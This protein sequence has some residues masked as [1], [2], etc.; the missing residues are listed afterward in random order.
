MTRLRTKKERKTMT[1]HGNILQLQK[2]SIHFPSRV[3]IV[4][5]LIQFAQPWNW[6]KV[7]T[8]LSDA[9]DCVDSTQQL[10]WLLWA[11]KH[12]TTFTYR[13]K[14][15][16]CI[17]SVSLIKYTLFYFA[18][19]LLGRKVFMLCAYSFIFFKCTNNCCN[20]TSTLSQMPILSIMQSYY[21][22]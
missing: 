13:I 5:V 19:S 1:S 18:Y 6:Q 10:L 17:L 8:G 22:R 12:N 15:F 20:C 11:C 3:C 16:V 2:M 9:Q 7:K 14:Y 21:A 4:K